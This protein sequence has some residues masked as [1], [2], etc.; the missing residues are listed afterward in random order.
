MPLGAG[1][2]RL[3]GENAPASY[4]LQ[5]TKS[6]L[7]EGGLQGCW[8]WHQAGDRTPGSCPSSAP[9]WQWDSVAACNTQGFRCGKQVL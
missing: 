8:K 9:Y 1:S 3:A 2:R 4:Q 5:A 6:C 7:L